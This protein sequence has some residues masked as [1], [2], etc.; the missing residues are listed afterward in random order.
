MNTEKNNGKERGMSFLKKSG[1]N[2]NEN[3]CTKISDGVHKSKCRR[4]KIG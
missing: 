4:S 3:K 2:K 1:K